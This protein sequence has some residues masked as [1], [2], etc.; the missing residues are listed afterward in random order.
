MILTLSTGASDLVGDVAALA[1]LVATVC[2][3]EQLSGNDAR[4]PRAHLA[5]GQACGNLT[6]LVENPREG[7][8]QVL[9]P[10]FQAHLPLTS[11]Q[12]WIHSLSPCSR[13]QA[14]AGCTYVVVQ[15]CGCVAAPQLAMSPSTR[16][17]LRTDLWVIVQ[18]VA[19]RFFRR[20]SSAF[21]ELRE[22]AHWELRRRNVSGHS[23]DIEPRAGWA[24]THETGSDL[25][26][27]P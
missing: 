6:A 12:P 9:S 17:R 18:E 3:G 22:S 26:V 16:T 8:T 25:R 2:S 19:G 5:S 4:Q 7:P 14:G 20:R 11:Q 10:L 27:Y 23:A 15:S 21:G 13:P 24:L 1:N